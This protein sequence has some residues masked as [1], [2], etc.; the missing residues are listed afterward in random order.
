MKRKIVAL[1][2]TFT[3][4]VS[5]APALGPVYA[6]D[7][8]LTENDELEES[9][10]AEVAKDPVTSE[11]IDNT[12]D[13]Q[14]N[15]AEAAED[16]SADANC[17]DAGESNDAG[18]I[19]EPEA[20]AVEHGSVENLIPND[21]QAEEGTFMPAQ[22]GLD[23]NELLY[24][25]L[26]K[27]LTE[28]TGN[29]AASN[30]GMLKARKIT[31]RSKLDEYSG[32]LYDQLL[33]K[34]R[35]FLD[36]EGVGFVSS[37]FSIPYS[38]LLGHEIEKVQYNYDSETLD[39]Y[40][41]S[42][43]EWEGIESA[44]V[45][46][47]VNAL[48]ADMPYEM[49][50]FDKS[51]SV[52]YYRTTYNFSS[53]D[54]ETVYFR[55]L[56]YCRVSMAVCA[57]YSVSGKIDT[58]EADIG[59]FRA[60]H[61]AVNNAC[62]IIESL[63]DETDYS[64]LLGYD[65]AISRYGGYNNW[66][67]AYRY[68]F[69]YGDPWQMIY[70]FD[71]DK[72]TKV[73]CEGYSKGFQ[74]LCDHTDFEKDIYCISV[75]GWV[76]NGNDDKEPEGHMW[77]I[78]HMEDGRNYIADITNDRFL[79]PALEGGSINKGYECY[80]DDQ[81]SYTSSYEYKGNTLEL[82]SE[83]ELT[84]TTSEYEGRDTGHRIAFEDSLDS[85]FLIY[86]ETDRKLTLNTDGLDKDPSLQGYDINFVVRTENYNWSAED[87]SDRWR[88]LENTD[89]RT[90]YTVNGNEISL[91]GEAICTE[92]SVADINILA[93]I[94]LN[95]EKI[96]ERSIW[97]KARNE[98]SL[99]GTYKCV[100]FSEKQN[101][102]R[103]DYQ[104]VG[105][106]NWR[107]SNGTL[108][109]TGSGDIQDSARELGNNQETQSWGDT[110]GDYWE[111]C[112]ASC[113]VKKIVIASDFDV[114]G[115]NAFDDADEWT[116]VEIQSHVGTVKRDAFTSALK[117][118]L[119]G[120]IDEVLNSAF[121][122]VRDVIL[123][124]SILKGNVNNGEDM[125]SGAFPHAQNISIDS[126]TEVILGDY[127]FYHS[128][129]TSLKIPGSVKTISTG[130]FMEEQWL[131]KVE[132]LSGVERIENDAFKDCTELKSV[133]IPLSVTYIGADAFKG[134]DPEKFRIYYE[135]TEE[136]WQEKVELGSEI[137]DNAEVIYNSG[138]ET[139]YLKYR[140]EHIGTVTL[141]RAGYIEALR[142]FYE[143][144]LWPDQRESFPAELVDKLKAAEDRLYAI[145]WDDVTLEGGVLTIGYTGPMKWYKQD[146][147][148]SNQMSS[149]RKV[150]IGEG[151]TSIKDYA[152]KHATELEEIVMPDSIESIG[153]EAFCEAG[154]NPNIS[155]GEA[156]EVIIPSNVKT[157]G[158]RAFMHS[159]VRKIV[160]PEGVEKIPDEF[161]SQDSLLEIVVLPASVR[162]IG[163]NA[164]SSCS[165]MES[166]GTRMA[167][168]FYQGSEE[169]WNA[170]AKDGNQL[171]SITVYFSCSDE[172]SALGQRA[173]QLAAMDQSDPVVSDEAFALIM[174]YRNFT[175]EDRSALPEDTKAAVNKLIRSYGHENYEN[176][177]WA[178]YDDKLLDV[179]AGTE[180]VA[181]G[182]Y[183]DN[184]NAFS[185]QIPDSVS[186]IE[187]D[188]FA[189]CM[190]LTDIELPASLERIDA[191]AF[192]GCGC[193]TRIFFRG[194]QEEWDR[195]VIDNSGSG[196]QAFLDAEL[197][198]GCNDRV[199]AI[200]QKF[201]AYKNVSVN[202]SNAENVRTL[203]EIYKTLPQNEKELI[204]ADEDAREVYYRLAEELAA[205]DA[206]ETPPDDPSSGSGTDG[207]PSGSGIV[208]PGG[209]SAA[210]VQP[211]QPAEIRDLKAVKIS[212]PKAGKKNVTVKWK[213]ISKANQKKMTGIEIQVA[214]DSGFSNLVKTTTAGKKKTS[215]KIKGLVSKQTYFVRIRAY[216]NAA[217]GK[218]VSAWKSK[219][220]K[221]K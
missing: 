198:I 56:P 116:E 74:F 106:V 107:Y 42:R 176:Y 212:K 108:T 114:I 81:K 143:N 65:D 49:F 127:V 148:W 69:P 207:T 31:R 90:C 125:Y 179:P 209:S 147:P 79:K 35:E 40:S 181:E 92:V 126:D 27:E 205:Y 82:Y 186:V 122:S 185:V 77:N 5:F 206:G 215:K 203:R 204:L 32:Y 152:F 18:D 25:Y 72:T 105:T 144:E 15:E 94:I 2:L 97:L 60:V 213:K 118:T 169:D 113:Y 119:T 200:K 1:M 62:E 66:A 58:T 67:A 123:K 217:D 47:A 182:K 173:Q 141:E 19:D 210:P 59:K 132:L 38:D 137:P 57:S 140:I 54:G 196:N 23:E 3:M 21:E 80:A 88:V 70:L 76:S 85:D 216:R 98:S 37:S 124:G 218:H 120:T 133:G 219:K 221:I 129:L 96:E 172:Y 190:N 22:D 99:Q 64:K 121:P 45:E 13:E 39:V 29:G 153:E 168:I 112:L 139:K 110:R 11:V 161:A 135:G 191:N 52:S 193:L 189:G 149:V 167:G 145:G 55:S 164:F 34:I 28:A 87:E 111:D 175:L 165:S 160:V 14:E 17:D 91:N 53:D 192:D 51:F 50:W 104:E 24:G 10:G 166:S 134:C 9:S 155:G 136:D 75:S 89:Y 6:V 41:L 184:D 109:I 174:C 128:Y 142:E 101:G 197:Y 71:G 20:E 151:V 177:S 157:I 84:I 150:V 130:L 100:T 61:N 138:S 36:N 117:L 194:T 159:N 195:I 156:M 93:E 178:N 26:D 154:V 115:Q 30:R 83:E 12:E 158:K 202:S 73:V 220:V 16:L 46:S 171:D 78:L 44:N 43:A 211:V 7:E 95:G 86:E 187:S 68:S 103:F 8:Q 48:L 188:A 102:T 199:D 180:T 163:E 4:I 146:P 170:V 201:L 131:K 214:T 162:E 183:A 33:V 63:K 208:Q